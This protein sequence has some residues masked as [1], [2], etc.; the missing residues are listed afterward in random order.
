GVD[1]GTDQ[2]GDQPDPEG[3]VGVG[4]ATS[5]RIRLGKLAD[6]RRVCR[7]I[8]RRL[9]SAERC[10]TEHRRGMSVLEPYADE[11][12]SATERLLETSWE[13]R[14]RRASERELVVE[15]SAAALFAVAA[16]VLV[17]TWGASGLRVPVAALLI[18]VYA[19]V[20]RIEFPVGAGFVVPTQP[21]LVPMLLMLPPAVVPVAVAIGLVS[22][23]V[24][25]CAVGRVPPRRI[26]SAIPD[27]WHAIGAALALLVAGSPR[28][29]FDSS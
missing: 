27:A 10:P 11:S 18:G 24:V 14:E 23:N 29:G 26:L 5:R 28:I 25:E 19:V 21:I 7:P 3:V 9:S 2:R 15:A 17:L 6:R 20:G 1:P 13:G 12:Q 16:A 22:G 4:R 8:P